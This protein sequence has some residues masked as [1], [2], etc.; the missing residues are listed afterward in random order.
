MSDKPSHV[1][2]IRRLCGAHLIASGFNLALLIR[3]DTDVFQGL[4]LPVLF[5]MLSFPYKLGFSNRLYKL[6]DWRIFMSLLFYCLPISLLL[7]A[8]YT[9]IYYKEL[10]VLLGI[11][12]KKTVH[13]FSWTVLIFA[14][15]GAL[16][17][18]KGTKLF[19]IIWLIAL[20]LL[21]GIL[22]F[23]IF[24]LLLKKD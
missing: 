24:N 20:L 23:F 17:F 9:R 15:T 3:H 16:L 12:S 18:Y 8:V 14:I 10:M 21:I 5:I 13:R 22:S 11:T 2:V 4:V 19:C 1:D 6:L 7:L